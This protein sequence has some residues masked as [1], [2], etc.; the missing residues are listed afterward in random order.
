MGKEGMG[1]DGITEEG[2][3][4]RPWNM[5]RCRIGKKKKR[6]KRREAGFSERN[7]KAGSELALGG[8]LRCH[9]VVSLGRSVTRGSIYCFLRHTP[10]LK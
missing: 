4:A 8:K 10:L 5:W 1:V 9:V 6:R 7:A 2:A 3:W